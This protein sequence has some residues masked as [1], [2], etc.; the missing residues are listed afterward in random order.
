MADWSTSN[1]PPPGHD[2]LGPFVYELWQE[3]RREKERLGLYARWAFNHRIYR[4]THWITNTFGRDDK[5][6]MVVNL[7]FA[8][9]ER[10][11]SGLT[12]ED[13]VA[14]IHSSDGILDETDALFS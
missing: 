12:S 9:I 4:G 10:T 6:K 7:V 5:Y 8:N 13:P 1:I 3:A 14:E 2:D 11:V